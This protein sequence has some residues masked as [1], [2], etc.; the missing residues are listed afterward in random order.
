MRLRDRVVR[1]SIVRW[2]D[3]SLV[4]ITPRPDMVRLGSVYGGWWIPTSLISHESVCYLAGVGLD[5]SF[6]EALI[7]RFRCHAWAFDPTPQAIEWVRSR[8]NLPGTWHFEP[9]GIWTESSIQRF[10][11]PYGQHTGS[12]SITRRGNESV[13]F[14]APCETLTSIAARLGHDRIDLLKLD[15]EGAEGPVLDQLLAQ[16]LRPAVLCVEFDQPEAPWRFISRVH[17]VL[18]A[19]YVL[20]VFEGWNCTF[21]LASSHGTS[22]PAKLSSEAS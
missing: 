12:S 7:E 13:S 1:N 3:S 8:T 4:T 16:E 6:D 9:I 19:G 21:T 10:C 18:R 14:L 22:A 5:T 11:A 2:I 17:R 20:N 15:I